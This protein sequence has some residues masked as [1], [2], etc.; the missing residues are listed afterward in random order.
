MYICIAVL[1][2]MI[3]SSVV[4]ADHVVSLGGLTDLSSLLIKNLDIDVPSSWLTSSMS[5]IHAVSTR[6][7]NQT[8]NE[9]GEKDT[10]A[11]AIERV[12]D[13][14]VTIKEV[15]A[16]P[17]RARQNEQSPSQDRREGERAVKVDNTAHYD[18][19]KQSAL[20][21]ANEM[22]NEL[23]NRLDVYQNAQGSYFP[24]VPS[25]DPHPTFYGSVL[26]EYV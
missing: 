19:N 21:L 9:K 1:M 14:R 15:L 2:G 26:G 7:P 8:I 11:L 13:R 10:F 22:Q 23:Q 17:I 16:G 12:T 4:V 3:A 18:E 25:E 5:H 24:Q 6:N 20:K